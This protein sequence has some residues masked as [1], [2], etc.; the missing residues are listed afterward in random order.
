[1][2]TKCHGAFM[3]SSLP[4]PAA[5]LRRFKFLAVI[6]LRAAIE[7][8]HF[9]QVPSSFTVEGV[10]YLAHSSHHGIRARPAS[11][12]DRHENYSLRLRTRNLIGV[13][14]NSNASRMLRSR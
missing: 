7:R 11:E 10:Q 9:G 8:P 4:S 1:M 12:H 14:P 6:G 13:D 2:T 5:R 3:S